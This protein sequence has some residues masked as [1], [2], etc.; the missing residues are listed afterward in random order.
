MESLAKENQA[1]KNQLASLIQE[2]KNN[3]SVHKRFQALE[4]DIMDAASLADLVHYL[5]HE[6]KEVLNVDVLTLALNDPES[7]I[8]NLLL[9]EN[10]SIESVSDLV[11]IEDMNELQHLYGAAPC[12]QFGSLYSND[13]STLFPSE[14]RKHGSVI[15]LPLIRHRRLIGSLNIGSY[16]PRRFVDGLGTD[17]L[18]R[19]SSILSVC[20]ENAVHLG[21]LKE[22]SLTD[23][24]TGAYN[25]RNFETRLKEEIARAERDRTSLSCIFIDIDHFKRIN[26]D[27][28]HRVGDRVL[29]D[30]ASIIGL[31]LRQGDFL[32]RYGGEEFILLCP[33]TGI[34]GAFRIAE[35]IR[36]TIEKMVFY[37]EANEPFNVTV[38]LGASSCEGKR[39]VRDELTIASERLV[40]QADDVLYQAKEAG[41]NQ[42]VLYQP[43]SQ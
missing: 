19:F 37:N 6:A 20:I 25:R 36:K 9:S 14:R 11:F 1:L 7:V 39:L 17:F 42:V 34:K 2:A 8:K 40:K 3:E 31:Q 16:N 21:R 23:V 24:L 26:D 13:F 10:A 38:S 27:Y 15:L 43:D 30:V 29:K 5:F 12:P 18:E 35:R 22:V 28:G 33:N 41:R 32:A 4:L